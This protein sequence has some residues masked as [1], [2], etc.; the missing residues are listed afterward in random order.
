[1][2][3]TGEVVGKRGDVGLDESLRWAAPSGARI[4]SG[5]VQSDLRSTGE[6]H[7]GQVLTAGNR[8]R[9]RHRRDTLEARS[10]GIERLALVEK[11]GPGAPLHSGREQRRVGSEL[12]DRET[13]RLDERGL[14]SSGPAGS[15]WSRRASPVAAEPHGVALVAQAVLAEALEVAFLE[16]PWSPPHLFA[17]AR[18]MAVVA[19]GTGTDPVG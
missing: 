15:Q 7:P 1:M 10:R 18:P 8:E 16:D 6:N 11:H 2:E 4:G 3:I 19:E 9:M 12:G 14:A 17:P 5:R 13:E